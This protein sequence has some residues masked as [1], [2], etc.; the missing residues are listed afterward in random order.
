M[1]PT[2]EQIA[3]AADFD[4]DITLEPKYKVVTEEFCEKCIAAGV[5]LSSYI[6]NDVAIM[7][8]LFL[9]GVTRFCTD[10]YSDIVFPLD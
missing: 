3:W 10:T 4:G 7:R 1:L 6:V 8:K 2:D 5:K 9:M